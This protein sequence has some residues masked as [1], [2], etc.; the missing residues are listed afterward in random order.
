MEALEWS[1]VVHVA[2]EN[3]FQ[4]TCPFGLTKIGQNL[5]EMIC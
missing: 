4:E 2:D 1:H 3:C 5:K